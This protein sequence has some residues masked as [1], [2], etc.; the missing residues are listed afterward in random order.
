MIPLG[1]VG[2]FLEQREDLVVSRLCHLLGGHGTR[3]GVHSGKACVLVP[4]IRQRTLLLAQMPLTFRRQ[5]IEWKSPKQ[6]QSMFS[7]PFPALE[8]RLGVL[9][10]RGFMVALPLD[11]CALQTARIVMTQRQRHGGDQSL[12]V[13]MRIP[14]I[15]KDEPSLIF[16][17]IRQYG[18]RVLRRDPLE[19][20]RQKMMKN[21]QIGV[22]VRCHETEKHFG[23]RF[24]EAANCRFDGILQG[25][26]ITCFCRER[27]TMMFT[28]FVEQWMRRVR[29][30]PE[31]IGKPGPELL[32][33]CLRRPQRQLI[34][35][36]PA[37]VVVYQSFVLT[38][39]CAHPVELCIQIARNDLGREN[40]IGH[41]DLVSKVPDTE[42]IR[43]CVIHQSARNIDASRVPCRKIT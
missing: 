31:Q 25:A 39:G 20:E 41:G 32:D 7:S 14:H 4:S 26:P 10:R 38:D 18:V 30:P 34:D 33:E 37:R 23:V 29:Q 27:Q 13:T 28:I 8:T 17:E 6:S 5:P 12:A 15:S 2:Q 24:S 43:W 42:R 21:H 1:V 36:M 19:A 16:E 11:D 35:V 9:A 40:G 22:L 3:Y